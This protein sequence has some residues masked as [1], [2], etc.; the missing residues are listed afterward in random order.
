M[1]ELL[2]PYPRELAGYWHDVGHAEVQHRLGLTHMDAWF[3]EL[4]ERLL[5]THLHDVQRLKDHRAPGNG[6][7]DF[8][9]LAKRLPASAARTFEVDQH[10]SDTDLE[11]SL[12]LLRGVGVVS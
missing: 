4:G 11:A 10:E 5:G 12:D 1:T 6:D 2:A 7:V 8:E 3:D 9:A